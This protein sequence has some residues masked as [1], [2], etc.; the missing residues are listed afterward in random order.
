[1]RRFPCAPGVCVDQLHRAQNSMALVPAIC[2]RPSRIDHA[3]TS[4][5]ALQLHASGKTT[6]YRCV[7]AARSPQRNNGRND[8]RPEKQSDQPKRPD[9]AKDAKEYPAKRKPHCG[10]SW[11]ALIANLSTRTA[12]APASDCESGTRRRARPP[13]WIW[14][15][16]LWHMIEPRPN[17]QVGSSI[18]PL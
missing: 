4:P 14:S 8:C 1:M 6:T 5:R 13:E 16:G 11:V 7:G 15:G 12:A 3:Q 17:W 9:P 18:R 10:T 2:V